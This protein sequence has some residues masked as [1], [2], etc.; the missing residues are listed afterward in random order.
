MNSGIWWR[1]LDTLSGELRVEVARVGVWGNLRLKRWHDFLVIQ[2]IPVDA[3]EERVRHDLL[4]V[5]HAA[6]KAPLWVLLQKSAQ[7]RFGFVGN[8][9]RELDVLHHDESEQNVVVAVVE[10]QATANHLVHDD[11]RAPPVDGASVV[12][13]FK[14]FGCEV[15]GSAWKKRSVRFFEGNEKKLKKMQNFQRKC[16]NFEENLKFS[17]K[18]SNFRR[19]GKIFRE[20]AKF[21]KKMQ[22][23]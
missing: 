12:V 9:S 13:V 4:D 19:K 1:K 6:S 3:G 16:Q 17:K 21:L 20:N 15:L 7:Q 2:V 14:N 22:S 8:V 10:R 18:M 23:F 5:V 11:A